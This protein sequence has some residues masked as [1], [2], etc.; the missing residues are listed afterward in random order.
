MRRKRKPTMAGDDPLAEALFSL[1]D[2]GPPPSLIHKHGIWTKNRSGKNIIADRQA[3]AHKTVIPLVY[4]PVVTGMSP[5]ACRRAGAR[6]HPC[7]GQTPVV[8]LANTSRFEGQHKCDNVWPQI[9][10]K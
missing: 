10:D 8:P 7:R 3:F 5:T 2:D 6:H 9:C 1:T 4:M